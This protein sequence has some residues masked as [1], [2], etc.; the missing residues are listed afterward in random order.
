VIT[1]IV[2]G[3]VHPEAGPIVPVILRQGKAPV[4]ET[5]AFEAH[6]YAMV[7][8]GADLTGID[9]DLAIRL[10]LPPAGTLRLTRP[11]P[12]PDFTAGCFDG[13]IAF[14]ATRFAPIS[15]R[16]VGYQELDTRFDT[17]RIVAIIGRDVLAGCQLV[18]HGGRREVQLQR[19][20]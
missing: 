12:A 13:E 1:G 3:Q 15:G 20:P 16:L 5:T 17:I 2:R 11:G 9:E 14:T 18:I 7:D 8:T 6:G 10:K 19:L 4:E